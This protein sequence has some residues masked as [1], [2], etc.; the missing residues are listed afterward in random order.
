[1]IFDVAVSDYLRRPDWWS[2]TTLIY[3]NYLYTNIEFIGIQVDYLAAALFL[4]F[5]VLWAL[6]QVLVHRNM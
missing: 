6:T 5:L 1:M 3:W 2:D 4:L